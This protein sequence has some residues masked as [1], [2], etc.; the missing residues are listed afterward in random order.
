[1]LTGWARGAAAKRLPRPPKLSKES[2]SSLLILF[3]LFDLQIDFLD[4]YLIISIT[5]AGNGRF[6]FLK[7]NLDAILL[8]AA[9]EIQGMIAS[10]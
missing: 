2:L 7:D 1:M 4:S 5:S 9:M 10:P 6:I 3:R 8:R